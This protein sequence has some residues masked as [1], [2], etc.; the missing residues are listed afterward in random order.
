MHYTFTRA[1]TTFNNGTDRIERRTHGE[2]DATHAAAFF[3]EMG[4]PPTQV[5]TTTF[6]GFDD[7]GLR[8]TITL[9]CT[10]DTLAGIQAAMQETLQ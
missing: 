9:D 10:P 8:M 3:R 4:V 5:G 6:L 1:A 7:D 2:T